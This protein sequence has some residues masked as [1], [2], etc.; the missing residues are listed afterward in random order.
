MCNFQ[1]LIIN[2]CFLFVMLFFS[3]KCYAQEIPPIQIFTPQDYDAEDQNWAITQSNDDFIYVAN[4]KG[5]LEYKGASW[6]LYNSPNDGILRSVKFVGDKIYSGGFM[7]FGYWTRDKLGVMLY[8]SLVDDRNFSIKEDEEFW[9]IIDVEGYILFQSLERIYIYNILED[10]F[11]IVDSEFRINKIFKVDGSIYFQETELGI[12]KIENGKKVLIIPE[13]LLNGNILVNIFNSDANLLLQTKENGFYKFQNGKVSKWVIESN[14]LLSQLSIYNSIRLKDGSFLLGTI[15]NGIIQ[16]DKDGKKIL[17]IDKSNG[18]SNNTI[19]SVYEDNFGSVWLGLDNGINIV[20]LNSAFKVYIDN[21]GVLGTIYTAAKTDD[22]LY[23]GT[24]QGLFYQPND[25]DVKF[26]QIEGT[27][28]QVWNLSVING[29]LFCGHDKGTFLINNT[30]AEKISSEL[31]SWCIKEIE[32]HPNLLIQGNYKGLTILEKYNNTWRFR[33]KINGFNIS[34]RYFEFVDSNQLLVSHEHKG[35]YKITLDNTFSKVIDYKKL[36]IKKGVKSGIVKYQN[37]VLYSN[38]S[39]VF[40]Y[41]NNAESFLKDSILSSLFSDEK[42]VSGK[43][44]NDRKGKKLWGFSESEMIF[45]EPGKLSTEPKINVVTLS[46]DVRKTKSGYENILYLSDND[47]LIGTTE[48]FLNVDLNKLVEK[49]LKVHM[50]SVR[51]GALPDEL[52]ELDLVNPD[53]LKNKFNNIRFNYSVTNYNKLSTSKY[54]SRLIGF[55]DHWSDWGTSPETFYKNLPHGEYTFEARAITD[56]ILSNNIMS[57]SFTINRPWYFSLIA[58]ILY[59]ILLFL[60]LYILYFYNKK[61]YE[62]KQI[63][64]IEKK[65]RELELEQLGNQRQ[66]IQF[67]N[68]NLQLDIEN[69]NRELGMATMNLVKRNELLSNIKDELSETKSLAD[70]SKVVKRINKSINNTGDWKLF[71]EA[72]NNVDK[73]FMKK[74]KTLHPSITASDLRLCAYLRLN[75]SS[76]EIAPLLNISHKSVEVKRYRLRK[77]LELSHDDSLSSYIIEL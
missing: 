45:V 22:F 19:L 31:G 56:G 74:I 77:K 70:V 51:Y 39:G 16:L 42:Y 9:G 62:R 25:S 47:Y 6:R 40:N 55:Y 14:N 13:V 27:K 11:D 41:D 54:Q 69:K 24:N 8:T 12:F 65:E 38:K 75:L 1:K 18:L 73:D 35:I 64:V 5:L 50:N 46:N 61:H 66:L 67:K 58:I 52:T 4:N 32:G 30:R 57:Y 2:L 29:T 37:E 59:I 36:P 28:G 43:L 33:N 23:L 72:F 71:E 44:F 26:K 34:S 63:K 10:S 76:K 60:F 49:S 68:K 7:D 48:G 3:V 21:L 53:P 20:N 17:K 15:A